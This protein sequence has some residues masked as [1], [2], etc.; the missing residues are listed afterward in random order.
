M[1]VLLQSL[2]AMTTPRRP[3]HLMPLLPPQCGFVV[4]LIDR[5]LDCD[6]IVTRP[7]RTKLGDHRPPGRDRPRHRITINN[8]LNPYAFLTTL[9]HELAHATTWERHRSRRFRLR[10]HGPEWQA[11][12]ATLLAPV[13][14][15]GVLPADVTAALLRGM[16]APRAS[17]C[18]DRNLV[19]ALARY[20]RPRPHL[21]RVEEL[22]AGTV[23]RLDDDRGVFRAGR[24]LRTR[25]TCFDIRTGQEYRIHGLAL[26]EPLP[27]PPHGRLSASASRPRCSAERK[28]S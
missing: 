15:S 28:R 11:E 2:A 27:K 5:R 21:V 16:R 13:V 14:D 4:D 7:R 22:D 3:D 23:F 26:V 18:S 24:L 25:R 19:L 10:P 12:F 9:L 20:D 17:S 6:I 8:D 1:A